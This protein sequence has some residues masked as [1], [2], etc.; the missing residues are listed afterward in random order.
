ME[1]GYIP[2]EENERK[3]M[4]SLLLYGLNSVQEFATILKKQKNHFREYS[5]D[6]LRREYD[7][8]HD[9]LLKKEKWDTYAS[10]LWRTKPYYSEE[11]EKKKK[12][13]VLV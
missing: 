5:A 4:S 6:E 10:W 1:E 9:F 11:V 2:T 13:E 7:E 3:R 8:L 12:T